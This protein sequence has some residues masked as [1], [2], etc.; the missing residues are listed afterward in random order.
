LPVPS[1][2][3]PPRIVMRSELAA[4]TIACMAGSRAE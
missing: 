2:V 4:L 3:P 1:I